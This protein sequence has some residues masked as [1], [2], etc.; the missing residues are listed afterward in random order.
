MN[1]ISFI[2]IGFFYFSLVLISGFK[3]IP[4]EDQALISSIFVLLI[5]LPHGAVDHLLYYQ[6]NEIRNYKFYVT[7]LSLMLLILFL[8]IVSPIFSLIFFLIISAYHFGESQFSDLKNNI[9]VKILRFAWGSLILG[10]LFLFNHTELINVFTNFSDTAILIGLFNTD[11]LTVICFLSLFGVVYS[12]RG[13]IRAKVL[14]WDRVANEIYILTLIL[15]TFYLLPFLIAFT[16]YF[17]ILHSLKVLVQEYKYLSK[18][19]LDYKFQTF[20]KALFPYSAISILGVLLLGYLCHVNIFEQ[21]ILLI[22]LILI[23]ML[24]L[25]HSIVMSRFYQRLNF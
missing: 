7:Y 6:K 23:S 20:V 3:E 22:S 25:P 19:K 16:L 24:T 15:I 21:S 13:L 1:K 5:G 18:N 10:G 14:D 9:N 11:V 12:S 17:C 2:F 4:I 8:W